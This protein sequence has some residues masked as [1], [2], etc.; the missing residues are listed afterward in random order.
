[1]IVTSQ[2]TEARWG[3]KLAVKRTKTNK[4]GP[5]SA[6]WP[7]THEKIILKVFENKKK[8]VQ[9]ARKEKAAT[10]PNDRVTEEAEKEMSKKSWE[11][12]KVDLSIKP[13]ELL[14]TCQSRYLAPS[15]WGHLD[16][17]VLK[18]GVQKTASELRGKNQS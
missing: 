18:R 3:L 10:T 2:E 8:S 11:M 5:N 1:M 6:S 14:D 16:D 13:E 17:Q 4:G 15:E 9:E 7:N 12:K